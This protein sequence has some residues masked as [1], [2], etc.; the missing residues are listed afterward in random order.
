MSLESFYLQLSLDGFFLPMQIGY[1][2]G[3]MGWEA[4][5]SPSVVEAEEDKLSDEIQSALS[6]GV[7][8]VALHRSAHE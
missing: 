1:E 2:G 7:R 4:M 5:P 6:T 8:L 3:L